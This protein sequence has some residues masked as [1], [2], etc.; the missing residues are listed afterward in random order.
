M[1][2]QK[3]SISGYE[4]GTRAAAAANDAAYAT[5]A[6]G[7]ASTTSYDATETTFWLNG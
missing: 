1:N 3:A 4:T 2:R 7:T 5:V 6:S